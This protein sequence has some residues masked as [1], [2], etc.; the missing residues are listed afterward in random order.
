MAKTKTQ[1]A[2]A[3]CHA[4]FNDWFAGRGWQPFEFQRQAWSAF[5]NGESGLIHSA[6][7]TGKSYAALGGPLMEWVSQHPDQSHWPKTKPPG[8]T[9]LWITP[10]RALAAD[11]EESLRLPVE[12]LGI[13]WTVARRTGD[14]SSSQRQKQKLQLP[15]LLITTP[16]SLSLQLSYADAPE[17]FRHLQAVVV[18]EWHELIGSK[19]GTM[20]ELCLARL[21]DWQP[22]LRVWGLSATIGNLDVAMECL[23]GNEQYRARQ[24]AANSI[25]QPLADV[26]GTVPAFRL[27]EGNLPKRYQIESLIPEAIERFPWAGH[28]GLKMLPQVIEAIGQANSTLVFTNVRSQCEIWYQ[29]LIEARP[30]W[31]GQVAIHHGSLDREVREWVENALRTGKLRAVVCTSSL[32]LGVDFSPVDQVIQVGSPKGVARMLQRAGRSG[33]QPGSISRLLCSP[34]NAFELIEFA[35]T[36]RSIEKS[37]VVPPEGGTTNAIESRIP[38]SK[39]LDLLVQH[40]VTVGVGTGFEPEAMLNEIRSTY[41]YRHLTDEEWQWA[42]DFLTHGGKTL[43]AYDQ[44]RKLVS[45]EGF[46][47]VTDQTIAKRHR[48]SIGTITSDASLIVKYLNGETLGSV[49]ESFAA[50][51]QKGDTFTF[52]GRTLEFIRLRE[53][54]VQ[55]RR[56]KNSKA[57]TP[58]WMGGRIPLSSELAEAMLEVLT[59]YRAGI[60]KDPEVRALAPILEIQ[61]RWSKVPTA[62]ELVIERLTTREGYHLFLYPFAGRLAND[63]LAALLALRLSRLQPLTFTLA[64]NDYGCELLSDQPLEIELDETRLRQLLSTEHL[65]EDIAASL[66]SV[67]MARRQFR[68]IAR[69]AG[70]VFQGYPG[71]GKTN[72]Q[73]QASSG[74]LYD[75]FA[76]FEPDSLLLKQA[77]REVLSNQLDQHRL[78]A[79]LAR[80]QQSR[81]VINEVA[82][83]TPFAFPLLVDRLR[84][85]LSSEKLADRI[86]RMQVA[87]EKEVE[88]EFKR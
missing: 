50:R 9:L 8:L 46:Y 14:T 12:E 4:L 19:R 75:V 67:E 81:I 64:A 85:K 18:D 54:T 21:R 31:I 33:H 73:L 10:L 27:I 22:E 1:P 65:D 82:R 13:P 78:R 28:I 39:P 68:E 57:A 60:Q 56:A 83:P 47:R 2:P 32:D 5:L 45:V 84:E 69:V 76:R 61:D 16:E 80:L 37:F 71:Q 15:S 35:A 25:H 70:L 88:K 3:S 87:L 79:T 72:K 63:G 30:D 40:L 6:T 51:L 66:N 7:G 41:A 62:G 58:R 17:K 43:Q 23:L 24:Q 86:R 11:T 74:L 26:R 53:M 42:L 20:T 59:E 55:V 34:T 36:R 29:A 77:H 44:Y 38:A 49:E 48:M 52:A